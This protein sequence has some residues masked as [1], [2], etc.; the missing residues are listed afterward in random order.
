MKLFRPF[1]KIRYLILEYNFS[2]KS[3]LAVAGLFKCVIHQIIGTAGDERRKSLCNLR[4]WHTAHK[5]P[6]VDAVFFSGQ[7]VNLTRYLAP[8]QLGKILEVGISLLTHNGLLFAYHH[9]TSCK[10][11]AV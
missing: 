10:E 4:F 3:V 9:S 8:Q 6:I 5:T 2:I 1:C 7:G 11:V